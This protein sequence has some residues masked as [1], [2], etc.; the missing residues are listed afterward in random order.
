[1]AY[2]VT[3]LEAAI[4]DDEVLLAPFVVGDGFARVAFVRVGGALVE[5]ME[6]ANPNE[7]GW[8]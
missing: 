1:V 7:E 4:G 5:Y 2:R 8:F 3:D 6:Y